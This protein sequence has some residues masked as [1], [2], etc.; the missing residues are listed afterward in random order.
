MHEQR[1]VKFPTEY[2]ALDIATPELQEKLLPISRKLKE[3]EMCCDIVQPTRLQVSSGC[4]IYCSSLKMQ[5]VDCHFWVQSLVN[6]KARLS[7]QTSSH[8]A[9]L[10]DSGTIHRECIFHE[11]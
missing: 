4:I 1:R 3:F 7:I 10:S 2:D 11:T 5:S 8:R 6:T 9:F